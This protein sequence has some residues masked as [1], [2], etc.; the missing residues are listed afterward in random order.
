MTG[1]QPT[2]LAPALFSTKL[3]AS[4][5]FVCFKVWGL[6]TVLTILGQEIDLQG[7]VE[8]KEENEKEKHR[9]LFSITTSLLSENKG[10]IFLIGAKDEN[11]RTEWIKCINNLINPE[12]VS[13]SSYLFIYCTSCL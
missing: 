9:Y 8:I 7:C 2:P 6:Y 3:L 13:I 12:L 1:L 11:D 5:K 10:R 4:Y